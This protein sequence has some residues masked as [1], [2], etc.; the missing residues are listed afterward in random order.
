[1]TFSSIVGAND[2]DLVFAGSKIARN[3]AQNNALQIKAQKVA[4]TKNHLTVV[5][6]PEAEEQALYANKDGYV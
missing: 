5:H 1:M 3:A 2:G 4:G 6:T